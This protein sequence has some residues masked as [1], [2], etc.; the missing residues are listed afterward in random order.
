MCGIALASPSNDAKNFNLERELTDSGAREFFKKTTDG[1]VQISF[2]KSVLEKQRLDLI[3]ACIDDTM[4][5]YYLYQNLPL[6]PDSKFKANI[7]ILMFR[8]PWGWSSD[9]PAAANSGGVGYVEVVNEPFISIIKKYLPN[10]PLTA[11]L[12]LTS[13]AR[14]KLATELEAAIAQEANKGE[15]KQRKSK[16]RPEA[17][18]SDGTQQILP[19]NDASSVHGNKLNHDGEKPGWMKQL[20]IASAICVFGLVCV[21]MKKSRS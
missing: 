7:A 13:K 11:D 12:L 9:N 4:T 1:N 10:L 19:P 5:R 20:L 8:S 21:W 16:A 3:P 14:A 18:V 2:V 15:T 6:V 17:P